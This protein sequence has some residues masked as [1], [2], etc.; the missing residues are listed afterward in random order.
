E[1]RPAM[2]TPPTGWTAPANR[3]ITGRDARHYIGLVFAPYFRT[4]QLVE[5]LRDLTSA[6]VEDMAAIHADRVSVPARELIEILARVRPSDAASREA[7][8]LLLA[9]DGVMDRDAIAPLVYSAFRDRVMRS[10]MTPILAPL[11]G[12]AL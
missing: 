10:L 4:R 7:L 11:A 3:P 6:T 8:D 9:W 5:R 1:A 12:A 2:R